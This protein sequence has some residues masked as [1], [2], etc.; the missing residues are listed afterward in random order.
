MPS[1]I[2]ATTTTGVAVTG[3]NSGA[4]ALQTNNGTTAVTIDTSQN[5]FVNKTAYSDTSGNGFG[6]FPNSGIPQV[7]CVG[8]ANSTQKNFT[9]Y[10]ST[11]SAYKFYVD[12]AGNGYHAGKV[13]FGMSEG[14]L[15]AYLSVA[16]GAGNT[17]IV[18]KGDSGTNCGSIRY[19]SATT[20]NNRWQ[21]ASNENN[22]F[23]FDADASNYA[24]LAQDPTAWSFASDARI[25][26]DIIDLPYGLATILAVQPR[27]FAYIS[28][29]KEDIGFVA[30]ELQAVV[31]EAVVG[32]EIPYSEDDTPMEKAT[33]TM[34]VSK[35]KLI[36]ILVKA[37][38]EL[39]AKVD[40]QA[41]EIQALKGVA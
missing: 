24:F 11:D 25:K 34:G 7:S 35:D 12:Y 1:I 4:L 37:L 13:G 5:F 14:T 39:N 3:D 28:D 19:T 8:A 31:P 22:Y 36:P 6:V 38:Q 33:K 27:R 9:V 18:L 10:S 40:A 41:L 20:G 16:S 17:S 30:Q 2:N 29:G 26:K 21:A 32:E 15:S 23:I